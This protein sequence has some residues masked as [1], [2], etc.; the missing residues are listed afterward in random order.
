MRAR[1]SPLGAN[2]SGHYFPHVCHATTSRLPPLSL[3]RSVARKRA[4]EFSVGLVFRVQ[5]PAPLVSQ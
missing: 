4:D 1:G 2:G 3:T 5:Q